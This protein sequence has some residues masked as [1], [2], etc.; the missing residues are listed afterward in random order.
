MLIWLY[1]TRS[2]YTGLYKVTIVA[3]NVRGGVLQVVEV[4][5]AAQILPTSY[6]IPRYASGVGTSNEDIVLCKLL[7]QRFMLRYPLFMASLYPG[8][9]YKSTYLAKKNSIA[10]S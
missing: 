4:T 7:H 2:Q 3:F 1:L 8:P 5:W 9:G 6:Y 10:P